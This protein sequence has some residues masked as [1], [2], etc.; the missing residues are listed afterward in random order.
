MYVC[1]RV[2][3]LLC[4]ACCALSCV[5]TDVKAPR[6]AEVYGETAGFGFVTGSLISFDS[7]GNPLNRMTAFPIGPRTL[8]SAGHGLDHSGTSNQAN[9]LAFCTDPS[10]PSL[11]AKGP[12]FDDHEF[13]E[14]NPIWIRNIFGEDVAILQT[15]I[16]FLNWDR[17]I[18]VGVAPKPGDRI[19]VGSA[20]GRSD[21][22]VLNVIPPPPDF[23]M[24]KPLFGAALDNVVF[25]SPRLAPGWS[26]CPAK[27]YVREDSSID[28]GRWITF[29]YAVDGSTT[30]QRSFTILNKLP[31]DLREKSGDSS[32]DTK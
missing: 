3:I 7:K 19:I 18:A 26:G 30:L 20:S 9:L 28:S 5:P 17:N 10:I 29:G 8:V 4:L 22:R 11:R 12:R 6:A 1:S 16:P 13:N 31:T 23:S 25:A 27:M 14:C 15:K 32:R 24:L 21:D 2:T